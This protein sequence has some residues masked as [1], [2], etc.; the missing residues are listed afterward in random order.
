MKITTN[1]NTVKSAI[2]KIEKMFDKKQ[3]IEALKLVKIVS[4]NDDVFLYGGNSTSFIKLKMKDTIVKEEG[5]VFIDMENFKNLVY[6][7]GNFEIADAEK[8]LIIKSDK[9]KTILSLPQMED[10]N[11]DF[12]NKQAPD[13]EQV[14][15]NLMMTIDNPLGFI[16]D[17]KLLKKT[18]YKDCSARPIFEGINFNCNEKA[19]FSTDSYLATHIIMDGFSDNDFNLTIHYRCVDELSKLIDKA[20]DKIK[21]FTNNQK[22]LFVTSQFEYC[23]KVIDGDFLD[24]KQI[25]SSR[26]SVV[27]MEFNDDKI[28]SIT[29]TLKEYEKIIKPYSDAK[30]AKVCIL[31]GY[32]GGLLSHIHTPVYETTDYI[33]VT[34]IKGNVEDLIVGVNPSL[35]NTIFE[36]FKMVGINA[37]LEYK[38]RFVPML[39]SGGRYSC[40]ICPMVIN[41]NVD[42]NAIVSQYEEQ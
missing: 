39:L 42:T 7:K 29:E 22:V 31:K 36:L 13:I 10:W 37:T 18:V 11:V 9:K 24:W 2:K 30:S 34:D 25:T 26:E 28:K 23:I 40:V 21:V 16:D 33:A 32:R 1:N 12:F 15:N 3:P 8:G 14:D 20:T 35:L 4:I 17:L 38:G 6:T 27:T 19:G 5:E 41:E